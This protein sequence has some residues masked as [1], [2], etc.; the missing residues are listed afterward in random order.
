MKMNIGTEDDTPPFKDCPT[1]QHS[2]G[3]L[4]S[5][6]MWYMGTKQVCDGSEHLMDYQRP[7]DMTERDFNPQG[8]VSLNGK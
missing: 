3:V 2:L 6:F 1:G 5:E 4:S 8:E 7:L